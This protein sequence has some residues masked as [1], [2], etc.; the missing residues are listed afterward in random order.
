MNQG[1]QAIQT[2]YSVES[3]PDCYGREWKHASI[4]SNLL[5]SIPAQARVTLM[6]EKVDQVARAVI[7][8]ICSDLLHLVRI[9]QGRVEVVTHAGHGPDQNLRA[10]LAAL[11]E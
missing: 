4:G 3:I 11:A 9:C 5:K 1:H 2:E 7:L 10:C 8:S 6:D